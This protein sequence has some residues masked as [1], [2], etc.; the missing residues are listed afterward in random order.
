MLDFNKKCLFY[1]QISLFRIILSSEAFYPLDFN[2]II[3]QTTDKT[4]VATSDIELPLGSTIAISPKYNL[5]IENIPDSICEVMLS[6]TW[7]NPTVDIT[8]SAI[9][10]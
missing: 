9:E 7:R 6:L 2:R 5:M 3:R 4:H 8:T 1:L 10:T